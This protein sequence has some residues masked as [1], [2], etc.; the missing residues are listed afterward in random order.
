MRS[1]IF[2]TTKALDARI[3]PER[4]EHGS[5]SAQP[6]LTTS[7]C[8]RVGGSGYLSTYTTTSGIT[9]LSELRPGGCPSASL[10][11]FVAEDFDGR[12]GKASCTTT[13]QYVAKS[14]EQGEVASISCKNVACLHTMT[15]VSANYSA[16]AVSDLHCKCQSRIGELRVT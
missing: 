2:T 8:L 1:E 9:T 10:A 14:S 3:E 4:R 16:P 13:K 5:S 12:E 6:G 7:I 11:P 15:K